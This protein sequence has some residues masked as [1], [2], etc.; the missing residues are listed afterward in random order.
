MKWFG[1]RNSPH[2]LSVKNSTYWI[3]TAHLCIS[4]VLFILLPSLD[5]VVHLHLVSLSVHIASELFVEV[6]VIVDL[7]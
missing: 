4:W 3:A 7:P 6:R 1:L 5:I 2:W